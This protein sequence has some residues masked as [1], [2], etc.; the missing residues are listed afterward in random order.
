MNIGKERIAAL[1]W[2]RTWQEHFCAALA[3]GQVAFADVHKLLSR[4]LNLMTYDLKTSY[5]EG[6]D[7]PERVRAEL[8]F[9]LDKVHYEIE[10]DTSGWYPEFDLSELWRE[11][12][13]AIIREIEM[14]S[15]GITSA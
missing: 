15:E 5:V 4:K 9:Y 7:R 8:N 13:E 6:G 12:L 3:E 10:V 14:R 2:G 11:L 1:G